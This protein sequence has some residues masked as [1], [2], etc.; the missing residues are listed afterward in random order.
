MP[1]ENV[2]LCFSRSLA[3]FQPILENKAAAVACAVQERLFGQHCLMSYFY[4]E[5][6]LPS[7]SFSVLVINGNIWKAS[8]KY[9]PP[10]KESV[11]FLR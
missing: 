11:S 5:Y 9:N 3:S 1:I 8:M 2:L 4:L 10:P 6:W 7:A